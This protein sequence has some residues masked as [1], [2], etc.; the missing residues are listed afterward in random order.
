MQAPQP[1]D[2]REKASRFRDLARA[3]H[4]PGAKAVF[5]HY[6]DRFAQ[7]AREQAGRAEGP[8]KYRMP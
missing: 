5:N 1:A 4:G 7:Q 8:G 3:Q 6:A 2:L